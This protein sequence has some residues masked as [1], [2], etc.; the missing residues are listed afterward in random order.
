MHEYLKWI[1]G[2][3]VMVL[4]ILFLY[5]QSIQTYDKIRIVVTVNNG[6]YFRYGKNQ[7]VLAP[8]GANRGSQALSGTNNETFE[9]TDQVSTKSNFSFEFL[10][11][12]MDSFQVEIYRNSTFCVK[13]SKIFQKD[14][15]FAQEDSK[16]FS[17]FCAK[18]H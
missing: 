13:T 7:Y 17:I 10:P 1:F 4:V 16:I 2:A 14:Y 8:S 6:S 15:V 11:G 12:K 5:D 3:L 18:T 9:Y